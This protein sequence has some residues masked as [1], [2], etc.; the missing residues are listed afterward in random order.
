MQLLPIQENI[1]D[2]TEK[3]N[4]NKTQKDIIAFYR[5]ENSKPLDNEKKN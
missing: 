4:I 3:G 2:K 5:Y 1:I